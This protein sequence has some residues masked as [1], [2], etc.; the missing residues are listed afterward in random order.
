M[1]ISV[2]IADD[3]VVVLRCDGELVGMDFEKANQYIYSAEFGSAS[4]YQIVDFSGTTRLDLTAEDLHRLAVQDKAAAGTLGGVV[5]AIVAPKDLFFG[6]SRMW[7][8]F[9]EAPGVTTAVFRELTSARDWIAG[10]R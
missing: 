8:V 1:P 9:A 6:F 2:T 10:M 4:R 5:I 3:G 7:Q